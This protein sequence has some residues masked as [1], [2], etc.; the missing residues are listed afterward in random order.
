VSHREPI[1]VFYDGECRLCAASRSWA[2]SRDS[3]CRLAFKDLNDPAAT[4]SLPVP[5][6][7]LREEMWVRLPEGTLESGFAAWLAVLRALPR[8]RL[9]ARVLGVPPLRWLGPPVYRLVARHRRLPP[10]P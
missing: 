5:A 9:V 2:E 1:E 10:H 7:R 3:E 6:E 8:W 4:A